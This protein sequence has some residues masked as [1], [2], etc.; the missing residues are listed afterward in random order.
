MAIQCKQYSNPVENKAV[1]E[2]NAGKGYIDATD[3]VV[4]TNSTYSRSAKEL[5]NSLGIFLTHHSELDSLEKI[6]KRADY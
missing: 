4:V 6:I 3:A 2:I 1:Q 5:A